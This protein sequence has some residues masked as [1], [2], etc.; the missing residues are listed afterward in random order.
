[1]GEQHTLSASI[2]FSGPGIHTGGTSQVEVRPS[3]A[4]VGLVFLRDGRLLHAR[5][6]N[7]VSCERSTSL[8]DGSVI[9]RT[10][11]HLLAALYGMGVD[12]AEIQVDGEEIPILDGSSLA[13]AGEID[14][15]GL[16][17]LGAPVGELSV[18]E[19][20]VIREGDGYL[21]ALPG[22]GC[23]VTCVAD[24]GRPHA[25]PQVV[26]LTL[27]PDSFLREIAPAR[28]FG[29]QEEVEA[30]LA[31]GLALGGTL[32]NALVIS[33]TGPSRPF[34][35]QNELARHKALDLIGDLALV[36]RRLNGHFIGFKLSHRLNVAMAK[37]LSEHC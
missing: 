21:A 9:I 15:V 26:D 29:F 36:G 22:K 11:E 12:N 3:G 20:F 23:R 30:L 17:G 32:D 5:A 19:P 16:Q 4:G 6:E 28:T 13:V 37:R 33:E 8:G 14:R 27:D 31:R 18:K 7:V 34:L 10:V 25:G 1:M 24:Y 35:F 2:L